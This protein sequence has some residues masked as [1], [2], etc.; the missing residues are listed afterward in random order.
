MGL[1][2]NSGNTSFCN[3]INSKI[4][5]D[6]TKLI[7]Y[8]NSILDTEQRLVCVSR[9][10]RFGKTMTA[11][12]LT[13]YYCKGCNS[14]DLFRNLYISQSDSYEKHLN[15]YNVIHVDIND[16]LH[17]IDGKTLRKVSPLNAISILQ[18]EV[19]REI[20]AYYG[21]DFSDEIYLPKVLA[22]VYDA[23][24][25]KFIIIIDEWD[26]IFREDKE[27]L[28]AQEMYMNLLRGLFK[29]ANSRKFLKLAYIT[30]ILPIKKTD[31]QSSLNDFDEFTMVSP[32][33]LAEY[34][35]FTQ[36]EVE[37]LCEQY[38]VDFHEMKRWYNGYS[39][40]KIKNIYN[41]N[42]VVKAILNDEFDD[43]WTRTDTYESLK[44]YITAN[45]DN[46]KDIVIDMLTG[47]RCKVNTK[48]FQNDFSSLYG[49]DEVLTLL[50]HLG[51]L[52]YD[53]EKRE[54][55][56]PNE[57]IHSEFEAAV[58]G[59]DWNNII[60]AMEQSEKLLQYTWN[61]RSEEVANMITQ[62]HMENTSILQYNDENSLSCVIRLAYYSA[63]N[64]YTIVRELPTG[65]GFAD[66][67]FI[68]RKNVDKPCM[69]VELKW[70]KDAEGAID[71]IHN[72]QY[73]DG[74][75]EYQEDM[76]L[77]GINYEKKTKQHTCVIEKWNN[78][79]CD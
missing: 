54:V 60:S 5:V 30:G 48:K 58:E 27:D 16:F 50:I 49:K 55:Y 33:R 13:A 56:I 29:D 65:L 70:D 28:E 78:N 45:V 14:A 22:D 12:M 69:I 46:L 72:N 18:E 9:P 76:L 35:G 41:P 51:Y 73:I 17:R 20:K 42:S 24:G 10:R 36:S 62:V 8:T 21:C 53:A 1:Y 25:D 15:Q 39:F 4:Y 63:V 3:V 7:E 34:V 61:R 75:Q 44:K 38:D 77:V 68:P 43:Y 31:T 59:T 37:H 23:K 11:D 32:G 47:G 40:K 57:E 64:Y 79:H 66:I 2:F 52:A 67:V 71:Q 6:K 26:A 19:I 74:L